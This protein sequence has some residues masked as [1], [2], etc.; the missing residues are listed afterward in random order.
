MSTIQGAD[1]DGVPEA[2]AMKL[3]E[4]SRKLDLVES[5]INQIDPNSVTELRDQVTFFHM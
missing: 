5:T 2:L 3:A 1:L 4:F